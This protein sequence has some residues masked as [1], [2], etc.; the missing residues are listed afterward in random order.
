MRKIFRILKK[1]SKPFKLH[2]FPFFARLNK[3]IT[4][5]VRTNH[6]VI[7][8]HTMVLDDKDSLRLSI[9]GIYEVEQTNY[10]KA[11]L[12]EGD[13]VIDIGA[14]IGY[15]ALVMAKCVGNRGKVFCFEPDKTNFAILKR[16][17][18]A[19]Q[20]T[21]RVILFND[22]V[23]FESGKIKLYISETNRGDHRI[24]SSDQSREF[25]EINAVRLD[26]VNEVMNC[27]IKLI[28]IDIQGSE[29]IALSSMRKVIEKNK[30]ILISEFWPQGIK[31]SGKNS[32]DYINYFISLGY[33]LNLLE[34]NG[35]KKITKP[36]LDNLVSE[37]KGNFTNIVFV[38]LPD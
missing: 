3:K 10:I 6:A 29:M 16:N 13:C 19:N 18:E 21:D 38:P 12:K 11:L 17:V 34:A 15:Y 26:E 27:N 24:Y 22:A 20:Y 28:K 30:P 4:E 8:G 14:N 1:I 2:R 5:K 25:I 32:D 35:L 37:E 7:D 33:T 23:S 36:E 31:M 9:N